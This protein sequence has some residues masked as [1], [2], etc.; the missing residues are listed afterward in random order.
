MGV[1]IVLV[2]ALFRRPGVV[3][4][5]LDLHLDYQSNVALYPRFQSYFRAHRPPADHLGTRGPV[6]HT[7]SGY[8]VQARSARRRDPHH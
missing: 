6:L 5:L 7:S 1:I 4:A 2:L 8:R 3:E